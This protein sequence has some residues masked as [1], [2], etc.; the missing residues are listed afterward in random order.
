MYP[1][2]SGVASEGLFPQLLISEDAMTKA[3]ECLRAE[4]ERAQSERRSQ[5]ELMQLQRDAVDQGRP[6]VQAGDPRIGDVVQ[7]F[8]FLRNAAEDHH[9]G[10]NS[11][12]LK[13]G[14]SSHPRET[15]ARAAFDG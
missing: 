8:P 12:L 6:I 3:K 4:S 15:S 1:L 5:E 2:Q 10:K 9:E 7:A 13:V 14:C 11:E